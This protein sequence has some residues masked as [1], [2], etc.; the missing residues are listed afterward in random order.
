MCST[1]NSSILTSLDNAGISKSASTVGTFPK[2]KQ[3]IL[4]VPGLTGPILIVG[5]VRA[6]ENPKR[7]IWRDVLSLAAD[8]L[9]LRGWRTAD[10]L[11]GFM[12]AAY[13]AAI[14]QPLVYGSLGTNIVAL[15]TPVK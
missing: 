11:S 4:S 6:K 1:T 12:L 14:A 9:E 13:V 10:P 8:I 7:S 15:M 5:S 3:R 2:K